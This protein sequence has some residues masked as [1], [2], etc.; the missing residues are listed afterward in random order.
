MG[1]EIKKG[2]GIENGTIE[3]GQEIEN[4]TKIENGTTENGRTNRKG[5]GKK[6]EPRSGNT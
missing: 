1:Q 3:N 2:Q 6:M 5:R 4:G